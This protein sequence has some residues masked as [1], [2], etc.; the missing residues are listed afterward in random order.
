MTIPGNFPCVCVCV[1]GCTS[2]GRC[3]SSSV[4]LI[5]F[6]FQDKTYDCIPDKQKLKLCQSVNYFCSYV[7]FTVF[8][9]IDY[10][11]RKILPIILQLRVWLLKGL[12]RF[13]IENQLCIFYG[14]WVMN[15]QTL[16]FFWKSTD[17]YKISRVVW[18][19]F[20]SCW[21]KKSALYLL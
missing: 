7:T 6:R 9:R 3:N 19:M 15:T 12:L 20:A 14:L 11:F 1:S 4:H 8:W 17:C 13:G 21:C 10:N 5:S 16:Q 18:E 2:G